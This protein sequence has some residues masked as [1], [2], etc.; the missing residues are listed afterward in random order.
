LLGRPPSEDAKPL[1]IAHFLT[2]KPL[3]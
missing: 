3:L 1:H 2:G